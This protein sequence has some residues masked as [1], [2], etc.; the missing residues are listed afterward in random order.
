MCDE[1][2]AMIAT[3]GSSR[4]TVG[5]LLRSM[6]TELEVGMYTEAAPQPRVSQRRTYRR[7]L[8]IAADRATTVSARIFRMSFVADAASAFKIQSE[9]I[10][11]GCHAVSY[12]L[13]LKKHVHAR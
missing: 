13:A 3:I 8:V 9:K 10:L 2:D 4:R 12:F 5:T 7:S 11:Q 6:T 1:V